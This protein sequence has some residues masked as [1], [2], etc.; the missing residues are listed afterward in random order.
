MTAQGWYTFSYILSFLGAF[1]VGLSSVGIWHFG[2]KINKENDARVTELIEGKNKLLE[3]S[4]EYLV[5]LRKKD[6]EIARLKSSVS[7][8]EPA[9]SLLEFKIEKS[10]PTAANLILGASYPVDLR[11]V[12]LH[13]EFTSPIVKAKRSVVGKASASCNFPLPIVEGSTL[14]LSGGPLN[15]SNYLLLN[16]QTQGRI[17]IKTSNLKIPNQGK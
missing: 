17:E 16:V 6:A 3:Q 14:N 11:Q 4:T 5:D 9:L 10:N 8:M 15:A 1:I 12:D 7:N 2:N 13:I